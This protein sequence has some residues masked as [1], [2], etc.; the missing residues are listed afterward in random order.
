MSDALYVGDI[1]D[2]EAVG[3]L[4][5]MCPNASKDVVAKAV[6]LFG[7][8]FIHL[9]IAASKFQFGDAGLAKARHTVFT[10]IATTLARLPFKVRTVLIAVVRSILQSPPKMITIAVYHTLV[11]E[12]TNDL[13]L[14]DITNIIEIK[15]LVGVFLASRAVETYFKEELS[16]STV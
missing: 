7:G 5:C 11:I 10:D 4:T 13:R 14:I 2:K 16:H 9:T 15:P 6:Q 1:T 12:L 8:R 3:Y